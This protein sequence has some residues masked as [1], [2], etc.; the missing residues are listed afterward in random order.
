MG[1]SAAAAL[2]RLLKV[3]KSSTIGLVIDLKKV[4]SPQRLDHTIEL[5]R[6]SPSREREQ[7][8][9][10]FVLTDALSGR[11]PQANAPVA[12][13][14]QWLYSCQTRWGL[15]DVS[16]TVPSLLGGRFVVTKSR[17]KTEFRIATNLWN[18]TD[19]EG[20]ELYRQRGRLRIYG[21]S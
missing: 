6:H 19:E 8:P 20:A 11:P 17:Y 4:F 15:A 10:T 21:N 12:A 5:K 9:A 3:L 1:E 13:T 16:A 7:S 14:A 2:G 18:L